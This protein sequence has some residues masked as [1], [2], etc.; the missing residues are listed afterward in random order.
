ML[1]F[2]F[3]FSVAL[4]SLMAA[5]VVGASAPAE[6]ACQRVNPRFYFQGDEH[7]IPMRCDQRGT[8]HAHRT[9]GTVELTALAVAKHPANGKLAPRDGAGWSYRPNPG[10]T[11]NDAFS[12]RICGRGRAGEGCSMLHYLVTVQAGSL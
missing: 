4:A 3:F 6:A 8:W 10:F 9:A 7:R 12:I 11:G 2:Q 5:S 1:N